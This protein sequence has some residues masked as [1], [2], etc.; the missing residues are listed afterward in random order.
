LERSI[1]A[2][3]SGERSASLE[4]V[5][6]FLSQSIC[7]KL[8]NV[9]IR[10]M[11]YFLVF[12]EKEHKQALLKEEERKKSEQAK[13]AQRAAA[14]AKNDLTEQLK[15][16]EKL[17]ESQLLEQD[18]ARQ[19]QKIF[20]KLTEAL[21]KQGQTNV[22]S[23]KV[24]QVM[25]ARNDKLNAAAKQLADIKLKKET[26]S[27]K[28]CKQEGTVKNAVIAS[29]ATVSVTALN[30]LYSGY[31]SGNGFIEWTRLPM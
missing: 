7:Y 3:K 6:V 8:W 23:T 21:Q 10:N 28:L 2:L 20:E 27:E 9:L 25:S 4:H 30:E 5:Q 11:L 14:K 16:Q 31:T 15:E 29:A 26:I 12:L 19:F 22:Q 17:E 13:E 18:T 1:V 24:A